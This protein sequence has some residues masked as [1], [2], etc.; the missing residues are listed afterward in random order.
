[1]LAIKDFSRDCTC[2]AIIATCTVH[3]SERSGWVNVNVG[4]QEFGFAVAN[5]LCFPFLTQYFSFN[6]LLSSETVFG[7]G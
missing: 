3:L 7:D 6:K 5:L 1:M 4:L 2:V